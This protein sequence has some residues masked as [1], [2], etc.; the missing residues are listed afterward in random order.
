MA[1]NGAMTCGGVICFLIQFLSCSDLSVWSAAL[2]I[3]ATRAVAVWGCDALHELVWFG[4]WVWACCRTTAVVTGP[5]SL[6]A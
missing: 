4:V 1:M 5:G 2:C 3:C 6:R